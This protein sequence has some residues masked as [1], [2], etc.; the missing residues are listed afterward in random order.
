MTSKHYNTFALG[1]LVDILDLLD[2]LDPKHFKPDEG[3]AL[4][5]NL[6]R[7]IQVLEDAERKRRT[8]SMLPDPVADNIRQV[9]GEIVNVGNIQT[10]YVP[11]NCDRPF[12]HVGQCTAP[13]DQCHRIGCFRRGRVRA[14][15]K[16]LYCDE[17]FADGN[18]KLGKACGKPVTRDEVP[19]G[20][21]GYEA[22]HS[23]PCW[24]KEDE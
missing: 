12:G 20:H 24:I 5:A 23:G 1:E 16:G 2:N 19:L 9:C 8:G 3:W 17:H 11:L 14:D 21:C 7:R 13:K 18:R 4:L 22:G 10:G 15:R 6:C